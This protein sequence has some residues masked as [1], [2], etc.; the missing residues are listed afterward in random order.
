MVIS[1]SVSHCS[2]TLVTGKQTVVNQRET[3][4]AGT[5]VELLGLLGNAD[6]TTDNVEI[7]KI[8]T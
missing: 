7:N 1:I 3:E 8:M 4:K 6:Q 5:L 2:A